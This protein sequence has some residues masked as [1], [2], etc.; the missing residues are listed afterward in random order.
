MGGKVGRTKEEKRKEE[1]GMGK[2]CRR[3]QWRGRKTERN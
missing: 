2:F 3:R 1:T